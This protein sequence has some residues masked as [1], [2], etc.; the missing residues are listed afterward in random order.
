MATRPSRWPYV[1]PPP[2]AVKYPDT[3]GDYFGRPPTTSDLHGSII[4]LSQIQNMLIGLVVGAGA[5]AAFVEG[6][7]QIIHD[8]DVISTEGTM[9]G[10]APQAVR[11]AHDQLVYKLAAFRELVNLSVSTPEA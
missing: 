9:V 8:L 7:E 1:T 6:L 2:G 11:I 5:S 3:S 10:Y 4:A